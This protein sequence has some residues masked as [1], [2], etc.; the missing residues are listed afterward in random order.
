MKGVAKLYTLGGEQETLIVS[1]LG[2]YR[3]IMR[4]HKQEA[5]DFQDRVCETLRELRMATG[6]EGFQVF[7]MLDKEHQREAMQ[8]LNANLFKPSPR[9]FIKA[10]TIADKA[11]STRYGYPKMLKKD[12]MTPVMLQERQPI[13]D[14]TVNLMVANESFGLGLSVSKT[15]YGKY[16]N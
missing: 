11:I 14:D 12:E 2:A 1:E 8:R 7:R 16:S 15:V 5:E 10:N 9:D 13:L 3:L 4:S 6:L